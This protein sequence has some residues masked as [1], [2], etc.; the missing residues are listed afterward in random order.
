MANNFLMANGNN[1]GKSL[2]EQ[3]YIKFAKDIINNKFKASLHLPVDIV[4]VNDIKKKKNIR[5]VNSQNVNNNDYIVDIGFETISLYERIISKSSCVIWNGPMGIIEI[6]EYLKGSIAILECMKEITEK[7]GLSIIGGGDTSTIVKRN[8]MGSFSH[9]STGGG[10]CLKL[11][12][13]E[14]M[15]AFDALN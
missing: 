12:S 11:L 13:G 8:E 3:D 14:N 15:P 6:P 2:Y 7:G 5:T 10:A 4:C 9:V 1:I